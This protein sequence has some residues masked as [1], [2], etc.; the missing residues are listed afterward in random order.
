MTAPPRITDS[1]TH[2][3]FP[4]FAG[5]VGAVVARAA[6]AGVHRMVTICTKLRQEP[7]VRAWPRRTTASSTPR[8]PIR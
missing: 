2:L 7:Q 3:D 1:H 4:D 5:E 8:A 6:E